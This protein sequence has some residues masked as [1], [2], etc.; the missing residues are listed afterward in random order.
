MILLK[1]EVGLSKSA[2][3]QVMLRDNKNPGIIELDPSRPLKAQRVPE[4]SP[5]VLNRQMS[6]R[7][8]LF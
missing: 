2:V 7:K 1:L 8:S 4:F 6:K 3:M 5:G